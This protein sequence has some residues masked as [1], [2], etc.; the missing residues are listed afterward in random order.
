MSGT[1]N[2]PKIG[3]NVTNWT[4]VGQLKGKGFAPRVGENF[5]KMLPD[6]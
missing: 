3:T 2:A 4:K 5:S 1:E 6:I